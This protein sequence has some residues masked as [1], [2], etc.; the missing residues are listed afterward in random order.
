MIP[1]ATIGTS[2]ISHTWI[3]NAA[4]SSHWQLIA[5][6]SRFPETASKFAKHHSIPR[7]KT[8]TSLT[9]LAGDGD[10]KAVYIASPNSLHYE[11]AAMML[12]ARKHVILEKPSCSTLQELDSL[13]ELA[14]TSNVML[15]EAYRHIHEANFK[16]VKKA[17][18]TDRLIGT[19]YG[20]TLTFARVSSKYLEFL[21]WEKQQQPLKH[22][23]DEV[24]DKLELPNVFS[25]EY[26]GGSLVDIGVYPIMFAVAMWGKPECQYYLSHQLSSGVDG[27][28]FVD[29]C[30]K[31]NF[32]VRICQSKVFTSEAKSEVYGSEGTM[33][34][35]GTVEID[36]IQVRYSKTK[37]VHSLARSPATHM[38]VEE[39]EELGRII[40]ENDENAALQLQ[41][42]SKTV[43]E[44]TTDLR[45][46]TG[47]VYPADPRQ[48]SPLSDGSS[49]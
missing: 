38:M 2:S 5:I 41:H 36:D 42:L 22:N 32:N 29:L 26:A 24:G 16:I 15:L 10:V 31:D 44:I 28:G 35:N 1:Y 21:S 46:Q 30:Y 25:A 9:A 13:F 20:A 45:K 43:L 34:I 4:L 23:L 40:E 48:N 12:R 8:Y 37:D 33:I 7:E 18:I 49:S 11:H 3:S 27:G 39:A 47:I 6:Y 17:L 14:K 19:F